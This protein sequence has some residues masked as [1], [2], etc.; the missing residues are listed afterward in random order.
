MNTKLMFSSEKEDW[1]TPQSFFDG[2]N[3]E[4]HFTL[5]AAASPEMRNVPTTIRKNKT[6]SRKAGL[7]TL[8][9]SIHHMGAIQQGYGFVRHTKN[10]S[11]LDAQ[12][13]CCCPREPIRHGFTST[14]SE[15]PKS[16]S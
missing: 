3:R 10:I 8:C 14:Y 13:S 4:F 16:D 9:G 15:K 11:E 5:D 6:G 2:L 7:D 1:E 12:L